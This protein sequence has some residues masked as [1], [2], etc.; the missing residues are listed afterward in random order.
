MH[1]E[2]AEHNL[3]FG[4]VSVRRMQ[5]VDIAQIIKIEQQNF[6][7]P[8]SKRS[9]EYEVKK[10]PNALPLVAES[11]SGIIG[12]SVAHLVI[13]EMHL[14][15]LSINK[16]FRRQKIGQLLLTLNIDYAHQKACSIITLEV[17]KSNI[18]AIGLYRKFGFKKITI[19]RGYY[20][21]GGEDALTLAMYLDGF[22]EVAI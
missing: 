16:E 1:F 22:A 12:Y 6:Q 20:E 11:N 14:L 15:N 13:D 4:T 8:W 19:R 3:Y 5:P 17:R 2:T 21:P 10:N 18:A 7:T 9:F